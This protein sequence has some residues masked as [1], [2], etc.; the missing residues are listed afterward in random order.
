MRRDCKNSVAILHFQ[1]VEK[2]PPLM[3]LLNYLG[4][5]HM[6]VRCYTISRG[7]G[8]WQYKNPF[9]DVYR[10][11]IES[12]RA[13]KRYLSFSVFNLFT[14]AHLIIHRPQY[15]F[16]Y[17]TLSVLPAYLYKRLFKKTTLMVHHHE[18]M[19]PSEY[20]SNSS[21]LK[22]LFNIEQSAFG[23][24]AWISQTNA[25]RLQLF[26]SS[27]P[28]LRHGVLRE[29]PN[30]PPLN[31][32]KSAA[33]LQKQRQKPIKFV[34]V[35][36]V[37]LSD[38]Y[39]QEICLWIQQCNGD[40]EL[41]IYTGNISEEARAFLLSLKRSYIRLLPEVKYFDLP[42]ILSAYNIG[43]VIYKG[44]S[45]NMRY[46]VPNKVLEY[47]ACGLEVWCS[48]KLLSTRKFKQV[49]GLHQIQMIDFTDLNAT[50]LDQNTVGKSIS[51]A[52]WFTCDS[53]YEALMT[54]LTSAKT[55]NTE[56]TK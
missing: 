25:D 36:A 33:A 31:W 13:V 40:A 8:Y 24:A 9:H 12:R 50:L 19:H 14:L 51:D 27:H 49:N 48:D 6:P 52:R 55:V 30:Y 38:T 17:D 4:E 20:K 2:F 29:F 15:V 37:S 47:Y 23:K 16:Y 34:Y 7:K 5:K 26:S 3:N 28:Q 56:K 21:Y 18:F 41:D 46:N 22:L 10:F 11:G 54:E 53:V 39:L 44:T 45:D 1:A 43:L 35:G 42:R 32:F